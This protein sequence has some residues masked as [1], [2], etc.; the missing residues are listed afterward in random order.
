M[1]IYFDSD[2]KAYGY[3]ID[4]AIATIDDAT[5]TQYAGTGKWDIVDGKF[6]DIT[7]TAEYK[8]TL[9]APLAVKAEIAEPADDTQNPLQDELMTALL[10]GGVERVL[11]LRTQYVARERAAR[12][13]KLK[14]ELLAAFIRGDAAKMTDIQTR[15]QALNDIDPAEL[16]SLTLSHLQ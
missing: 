1:T 8:A 6:T 5:W 15:C 4:S 9:A 2:K 13:E 11:E 16:T 14:A 7:D 10:E 12:A 3:K